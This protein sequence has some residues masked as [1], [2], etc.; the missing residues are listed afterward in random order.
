MS[1]DHFELIDKNRQAWDA[2]TGIHVNSEFYNLDSFLKGASSLN[3]TEKEEIGNI[4]GKSLLHLQ[5]HFGM[6]T[7]SLERLGAK[8]TG[9][10]ISKES[11][12]QAMRI[13]RELKMTSKFMRSD[14]Y[15]LNE[16]LSDT[17]D[18]VYT[19][20]GVLFWLPDLDSWAKIIHDRLKPGGIFYIVE[21]HPFLDVIDEDFRFFKYPYFNQGEAEKFVGK[22]TYAERNADIITT[23][24]GWMHSLS[25]VHTALG[26]NGLN[27]SF[28]HEFSYSHY[29]LFPEMN[30]YSPG[31][32]VHKHLKGSIPYMY[33]IMARK[34]E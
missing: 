20:Y 3:S 13:N 15:E 14:I 26:D 27:V 9:V 21:F 1:G 4:N 5:C 29:N 19:S 18:I 22:G 31:K 12:D 8:C 25:E 6:D 17:F 23:T 11:I 7:I 34:T 24:Y 28:F 32:F 33:S 2:Y 10:D 16:I 30:E